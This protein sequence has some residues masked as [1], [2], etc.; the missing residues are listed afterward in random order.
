MSALHWACENDHPE[1][2]KL[3][4]KAGANVGLVNKFG[5]TALTLALR[6]NQFEICAMLRVR[7]FIFVSC[8]L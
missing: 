8:L 2:V 5:K 4:L 3:L 1:C 7:W 6:K